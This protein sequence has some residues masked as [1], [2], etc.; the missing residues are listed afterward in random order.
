VKTVVDNGYDLSILDTAPRSPSIAGIEYA[1]EHIPRVS[2]GSSPTWVW[3][4]LRRVWPRSGEVWWTL[5]HILEVALTA[6]RV[7]LAAYRLNA[8][9]YQAHDLYA[10]IPAWLAGKAHRRQVIYDA[11]EFVSE[12]GDPRSLRN[13]FERLV[14][15]WLVPRADKLIVPSAARGRLYVERYGVRSRPIL[16]LNCPPTTDIAPS[17][18]IHERLGLPVSTRVVLYHGTFMP[19]R[20]LEH[21]LL[22]ARAFDTGTVLVMIGAENDFFQEV[23][24]PLYRTEHLEHRVFFIPFLPPD[25]VQRYVASADLGVVIY[26]NINLNNYFCAPTKLYE[27]LMAGVPVVLS[28][29]PEMLEFLEEYPVGA[30]FDPEDPMS[31]AVAVNGVLRAGPVETQLRTDAVQHARTH[32]TWERESHKLLEVF[33]TPG[34]TDHVIAHANEGDAVARSIS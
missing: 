22:S 10:L 17:R 2:L 1:V 9:Y 21:L 5:V 16:V 27:F 18:V 34:S 8:D 20:A 7:A 13:Q 24:H 29:F 4:I 30:A 6:A 3:R 32:F 12:Q 19:G 31:I 15:K 26:R 14:E 25:E 11:H 23:L 28:H 33:A